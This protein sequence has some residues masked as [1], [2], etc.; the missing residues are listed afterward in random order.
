LEGVTPCWAR[1]AGMASVVKRARVKVFS[2]LF[3]EVLLSLLL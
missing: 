2:A 1:A 3:I